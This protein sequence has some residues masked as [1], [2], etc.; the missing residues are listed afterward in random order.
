MKCHINREHEN[1]KFYCTE[2]DCE[3]SKSTKRQLQNHIDSFHRGIKY[4]CDQCHVMTNN[5]GNLRKHMVTKHG[6]QLF[7]CD[8]CPMRCWS[9]EKMKSHMLIHE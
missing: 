9:S 4:K 1:I 7:A 8:K 6:A 5:E 3:V 2:E